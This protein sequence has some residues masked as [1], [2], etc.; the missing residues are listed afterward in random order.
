MA[1]IR[2]KK[3]LDLNLQGKVTGTDIAKASI[4][5]FYAIIPDDYMGLIPRLD[6][7]E[8]SKVVAGDVLYHDKTFDQIKVTS[9]VSG[10]IVELR[11]GERRKLLA[12]VIQADKDQNGLAQI[13]VN[14]SNPLET[15]LA[16]GFFAQLRQRPYDVVPDPTIQPRDIFV[17]AFD[18]APLAPKLSVVAGE[19]MQ[20][21]SR[22][23]EVLSKL[24]TGRIY[25]SCRPGEEIE[26][27]NAECFTIEGPHPAGNVGVQIANIKPVNKGEVVWT[28]DVVTLARIGEMFATGK[29]NYNTV[30]ALTGSE[31]Q[32][33]R[34]VQSIAGCSIKSLLDK[35]LGENQRVISGTVL[36]GNNVGSDGF[37]RFPFRQVT[38]IPE[39][40]KKDEFM[41]W[42]SMSPK[43]YST[44]RLFP[45][46]LFG[47]LSKLFAPDAKLNGGERAIVMSGEYDRFLPMDI[48]GEFLIKAIIA[49]DIDKMEQLGIYEIAPE[50]FA[51]AEFA[52]TSKLE[53]QRIIRQGLDRMRKELS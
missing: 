7:K 15:L 43:K 41:G 27:P 8:G 24:T 3:G 25:V 16:S 33:P 34:M 51:L 12:I 10:T 4:S 53:L 36:T 20:Y 29:V 9:P 1:T 19:S 48:Y 37:L 30:V 26:L 2:L 50:D 47:G 22:G 39:V 28:L 11:R 13:E 6:V 17:T 45:S 21:L 52:D 18:S 44:T 42:L 38:V 32:N 49:F 14:Q 23:V 46:R 5:E 40:S 35:E 31:V